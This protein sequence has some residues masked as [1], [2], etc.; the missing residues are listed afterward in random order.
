VVAA[1]ATGAVVASQGGGATPLKPVDVCGGTC[2]GTINASIR[3]RG[4]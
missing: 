4:Y 1:A 2:D 3:L